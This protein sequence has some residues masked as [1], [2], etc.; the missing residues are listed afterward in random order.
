MF[1]KDINIAQWTMDKAGW[2]WYALPF[3]AGH[4]HDFIEKNAPKKFWWCSGSFLLLLRTQAIGR[5]L[6]FLLDRLN[7]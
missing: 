6:R 3:F 2:Y 7:C 5:A 4:C 1:G